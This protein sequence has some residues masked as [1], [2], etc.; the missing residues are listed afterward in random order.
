MSATVEALRGTKYFPT[1]VFERQEGMTTWRLQRW[2]W[3]G[4]VKLEEALKAW[5]L[6]WEDCLRIAASL[7]DSTARLVFA[8]IRRDDFMLDNILIERRSDKYAV[9]QIDYIGQ[10]DTPFDWA[11]GLAR[12]LSEIFTG[13]DGAG[14]ELI[15]EL[16]TDM[17][18]TSEELITDCP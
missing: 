11:Q 3:V 17:L 16:I 7:V 6:G 5:Q 8:R 14:I 1:Q 2:G 4:G 10:Q 15:R 13:Q 18:S 12:I 9:V